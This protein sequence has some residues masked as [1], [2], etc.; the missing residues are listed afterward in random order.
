MTKLSYECYALGDSAIVIQFGEA[1]DPIVHKQILQLAAYIEETSFPGYRETVTAYTTI[2][3]FYDSYAVFANQADPSRAALQLPF[4]RVL[5]YIEKMI[6]EYEQKSTAI[7]HHSYDIVEIPVCYGGLFGPDLEEVAVYHGIAAEEVIRHHTSPIYPVYMIGFAPGFPYLGGMDDRIATPRRT[8]P[9][10]R[11][12][13]GSVGI[14]G[15]QTG[16]Y[17]LETPGGWNLIGR[18]PLALFQPRAS[19][20]PSLLKVG[21]QVRFVPI[22][23]EQ[24]DLLAEGER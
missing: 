19:N 8:I 9:R 21:D 16:I 15:S 1:I 7:S 22:T 18:T 13:A 2:T 4:E 12:P 20:P 5:A 14:G 10:V 11:I 24:F 17:P 23:P 6:S 3:I